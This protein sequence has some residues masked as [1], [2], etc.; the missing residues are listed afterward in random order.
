MST[1]AYKAIRDRYSKNVYT[2]MRVKNRIQ[3]IFRLLM[4]ILLF[5]LIFYCQANFI[6]WIFI[7][8]VLLNFAFLAKNDGKESTIKNSLKIS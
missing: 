4:L 6:N 3:D 1:E 5:F 2:I 8:L 7:I